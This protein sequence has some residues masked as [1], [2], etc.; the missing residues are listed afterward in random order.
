MNKIV[1][2]VSA[3]LRLRLLCIQGKEQII[4][5]SDRGCDILAVE[6]KLSSYLGRGVFQAEGM[7]SAK[8]FF[9]S[10]SYLTQW[11][12]STKMVST[13]CAL[14]A[15]ARR[16]SPP[17]ILSSYSTNTARILTLPATSSPNLSSHR[18]RPQGNCLPLLV[19]ATVQLCARSLARVAGIGIFP[20][21]VLRT[22]AKS[23]ELFKSPELPSWP[24]VVAGVRGHLASS[25]GACIPGR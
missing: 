13:N 1:D 18:L 8:A 4:S 10:P 15:L 16:T 22:G 20:S 5:E 6:Y 24:Q 3:L 14:T 25:L 23:F 17:Q 7:T 9:L 19:M 2:K 12:N 21:H 11:Q